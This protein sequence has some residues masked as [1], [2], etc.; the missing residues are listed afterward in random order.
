VLKG[1]PFPPT[2][3]LRSALELR[4]YVADADPNPDPNEY[5]EAFPPV[6][7]FEH[8]HNSKKSTGHSHISHSRETVNISVDLSDWLAKKDPQKLPEKIWV[9]CRILARKGAKNTKG[10]SDYQKVLKDSIGQAKLG[11]TLVFRTTTQT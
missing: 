11:V 7:F 4:F 5:R 10:F 6:S 3:E 1:I 9:S 8:N 2:S